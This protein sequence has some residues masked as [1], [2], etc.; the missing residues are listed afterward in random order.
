MRGRPGGG[1]RVPVQT[2]VRAM[3]LL[4]H[5]SAKRECE[6]R[7]RV[8]CLHRFDKAF[9][10]IVITNTAAFAP[11]CKAGAAPLHF[12]TSDLDAVIAAINVSIPAP[13]GH[14]RVK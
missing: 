12:R 1:A 2:Q 7:A 14:A 3:P 6:S 9:L 4:A 8:P 13:C 11:M 5:G 10:L